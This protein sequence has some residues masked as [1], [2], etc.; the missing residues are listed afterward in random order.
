M[1]ETVQVA[2]IG[3]AGLVLVA[4]VTLISNLMTR[5]SVRQVGAQAQEAADH[6]AEQAEWT[7][8]NLQPANG[9]PLAELV[10][11][12]S[13]DVHSIDDKLDD[14]NKAVLRHLSDS[15]I[16]QPK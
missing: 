2:I 3:A 5:R 10:Q 14:L 12:I 15:A 9:R 6:A 1:S 8:A 7:G 16:H 4:L 13:D 11:N